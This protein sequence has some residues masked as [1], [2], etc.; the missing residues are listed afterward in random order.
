MTPNPL[1]LPLPRG[2]VGDIS[3]SFAD[4]ASQELQSLRLVSPFLLVSRRWSGRGG[5]RGADARR[6]LLRPRCFARTH[7]RGGAGR[8]GAAHP[9]A[10]SA[11]RR[12]GRR[13]GWRRRRRRP[14]GGDQ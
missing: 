3:G 8:G 4:G 5:A 6:A 13:R 9:R 1:P 12:R 10:L 7:Q 2:A 11:R 14:R